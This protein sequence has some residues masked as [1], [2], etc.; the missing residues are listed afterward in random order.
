MYL[1]KMS[2]TFKGYWNNKIKQDLRKGTADIFAVESFI[3]HFIIGNADGR[4]ALL[5]AQSYKR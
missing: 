2:A 3:S 5:N 4:T 1:S